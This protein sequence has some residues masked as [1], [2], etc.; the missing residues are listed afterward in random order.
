M[1]TR[2]EPRLP[3]SHRAARSRS[4]FRQRDV[5][6]AIRATERAG[7]AISGIEIDRNGT[8]RIVLQERSGDP[9]ANE[10]DEDCK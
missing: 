5:H 3:S 1:G 9:E 8:I 7:K 10:W 6:A 4:T 2:I